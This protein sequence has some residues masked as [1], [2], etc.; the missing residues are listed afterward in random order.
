MW[1]KSRDV[2][3][4]VFF[5][6]LFAAGLKSCIVDAFRIP[7][8]SMRE[9][10]LPGDFLL[11]NK[12]IYGARTPSS[13]LYIPLP[14][15][16]F[17][18]LSKI[19]HGDVIVFEF[20]GESN[21][22]YPVR[23]QF[24]VKRCV[25]L[26]HDTVTIS[27]GALE[28]NGRGFILKKKPDM[29]NFFTTIVPFV[30]MEILLDTASFKQWRVFI[31]REGHAVEQRGEKIYVDNKEAHAYRVE[32]NYYFALGDNVNNSYDSRFWGCVPEENIIG[33]PMLIYWSRDD[34]GIRWNRIG[35]LIR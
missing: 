13:I 15:F 12:F 6:V 31:H 19:H 32:K 25:G 11:V 14:S 24:L 5:T 35:Q 22:L 27:N 7:T 4:I 20:P 3:T 8:E 34:N 21:E 18:K 26:P 1:R 23:H 9:T 10:L 29:K 28:I 17:P 16:Q 30:G 2:V 33:K